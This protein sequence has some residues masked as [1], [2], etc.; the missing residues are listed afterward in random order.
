M[1][2]DH[3]KRLQLEDHQGQAVDVDDEIGAA[4]TAA[5]DRKPVDRPEIV[6]FRLL[7]MRG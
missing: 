7:P 3:A 2:L 6:R 5:P 1:S 4:T